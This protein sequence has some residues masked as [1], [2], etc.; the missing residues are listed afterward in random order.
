MTDTHAALTDDDVRLGA[1][2]HVG[3]LRNDRLAARDCGARGRDTADVSPRA[4]KTRS[5]EAG[6]LMVDSA[7]WMVEMSECL[8][9]SDAANAR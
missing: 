5:G 7:T 8:S 3:E 2:P 1:R 9:R 4:Q 6:A